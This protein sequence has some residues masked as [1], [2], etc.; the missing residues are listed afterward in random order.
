MTTL[1][2]HT[3]QSNQSCDGFP[4]SWPSGS[5]PTEVG[6]PQKQG[7]LWTELNVI[8]TGNLFGGN[9][10]PLH[11]F[12]CI[13]WECEL[14]NGRPKARCYQF[15]IQGHHFRNKNPQVHH[16]VFDITY[17]IR[18][19][20]IPD[21][22]RFADDRVRCVHTF[23]HALVMDG[24]EVAAALLCDVNQCPVCTCPHSGL[25]RTDIS[26]PY[27]DTK[28]VKRSVE[29]AHSEHFDEDCEVKEL[30]WEEVSY[31]CI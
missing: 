3:A 30:H 13:Q 17:D 7:S 29:E 20:I 1:P 4:P 24:A 21:F 19:D 11:T 31:Y 2:T 23:F 14:F 12:G 18:P 26:Y 9:H 10:G 15:D 6:I 5:G 16:I 22:M 25:D 27:C 28:T 8:I